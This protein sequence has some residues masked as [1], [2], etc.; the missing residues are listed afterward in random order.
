MHFFLGCQINISTTII[1]RSDVLRVLSASDLKEEERQDLTTP[2]AAPEVKSPLERFFKSF[3]KQL[4]AKPAPDL[5]D[6]EAGMEEDLLGKIQNTSLD[7]QKRMFYTAYSKYLVLDENFKIHFF[8]SG[9]VEMLLIDPSKDNKF[10][11]SEVF[12]ILT[13]YSTYLPKDF[14]VN[15]K[16]SIRMGRALSLDVNLVTR[17]SMMSM[18]GHEKFASHWTPLKGENAAVKFVVVC[19]ASYQQ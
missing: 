14:K 6:R 1:S 9:I 13:Q 2:T 5:A 19:F 4:S 12:A 11:G 10:V 15:V 8:S 7:N 17:R 18:K 3:R 16:S